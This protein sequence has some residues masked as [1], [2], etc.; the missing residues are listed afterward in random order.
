MCLGNG[1]PHH[2]PHSGRNV[3]LHHLSLHAR[4]LYGYVSF[5]FVPSLLLVKWAKWLI[6]YALMMMAVEIE[7]EPQFSLML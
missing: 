1:A 6:D 7:N 3:D 2:D 5:G 4:I